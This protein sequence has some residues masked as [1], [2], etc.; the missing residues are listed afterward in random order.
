M[1][2]FFELF[3]VIFEESTSVSNP[4]DG[5]DDSVVTDVSWAVSIDFE[6][7]CVTCVV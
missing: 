4:F 6:V 2:L 5:L 3:V 1:V 7:V